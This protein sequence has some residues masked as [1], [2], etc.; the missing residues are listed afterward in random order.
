M[1]KDRPQLIKVHARLVIECMPSLAHDSCTHDSCRPRKP[2][3]IAALHATGAQ[4]RLAGMASAPPVGSP[5]RSK[6]QLW[7]WRH[8]QHR[9]CVALAWRP[10]ASAACEGCLRTMCRSLRRSRRLAWSMACSGVM[11]RQALMALAGRVGPAVAFRTVWRMC[12]VS[13]HFTRCF[14]GGDTFGCYGVAYSSDGKS[15]AQSV[16]YSDR[17]SIG[18][19]GCTGAPLLRCWSAVNRD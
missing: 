19:I 16:L 1:L 3:A 18:F 10:L 9:A 4:P 12:I 6:A 17:A 2:N 13:H 8:R 11:L 7:V 5:V 14:L 15:A